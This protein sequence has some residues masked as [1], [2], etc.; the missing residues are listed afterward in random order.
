MDQTEG[1]TDPTLVTRP[2]VFV[3]LNAKSGTCVIDDVKR[4]FA[5]HAD[6]ADLR[7]HELTEDE[8]W[9][10]QVSRA[11]GEGYSQFVAGGG[12]GTISAIGGLLVN[13]EVEFAVLPLGTAN[14]LA[15]E[16]NIPTDLAGACRLAASRWVERDHEEKS[17]RILEIDAM[18][19]N[20][21][22]Y[23]TQVGVGIDAMMIQNTSA[24]SKRRLGK[25]AYMISATRHILAFQLRKFTVTI[26]GVAERL[27]ASEIVVANTGMMGQRSLRW[28]PDILPNDG[29][30]NA[31]FVKSARLRDYMRLFWVV[32]RG[33]REKS[34]HM[35]HQVVERAITIEA[36]HELPVQA[37]GEIIGV[38]PVT[39]AVVPRALKVVVPV[40][41]YP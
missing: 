36:R 30:L 24:E 2:K 33:H 22:H 21:H 12:D 26:D 34:P 16:L 31:C 38:T 37:D 41:R 8:D 10:A 7:F 15:L 19:V 3:I 18:R 25:L 1:V 20:D 28:G 9:Q 5:P 11:V 27:R 17:S 13:S 6:Q 14:V 29:R 40:N 4:E 35:R 39:I 23:L 32:F